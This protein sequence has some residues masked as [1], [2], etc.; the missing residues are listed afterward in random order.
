VMHKERLVVF[1]LPPQG[2]GVVG[3][4]DERRID[5]RELED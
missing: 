2:N 3:I 4:G 5:I 1:E